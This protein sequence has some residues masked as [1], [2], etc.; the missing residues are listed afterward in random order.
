MPKPTPSGPSG[1]SRHGLTGESLKIQTIQCHILSC[2]DAV[3]LNKWLSLYVIETRKQ[4]GGRYPASTLNL[5]LCGLK[6][7]MKKVNPATPNFLDEKDD[8]FAGLRG[9]RDVVARKLREDGG[10]AY[11]KVPLCTTARNSSSIG[12]EPVPYGASIRRSA[13][14]SLVSQAEQSIITFT[15]IL[16]VHKTV[17][18]VCSTSE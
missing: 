4:D 16:Q 14:S 8:R 17:V 9:T 18:L 7:H 11:V 2:G 5:L 12:E 10:G 3:A 15:N 13:T 6:R 1:V